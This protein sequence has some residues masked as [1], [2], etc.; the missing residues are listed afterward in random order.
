[1]ATCQSLY[2]VCNITDVCHFS[3]VKI[4]SFLSSI[5]SFDTWVMSYCRIAAHLGFGLSVLSSMGFIALCCTLIAM[6]NFELISVKSVDLCLGLYV[7]TCGCL[8]GKTIFSHSIFVK[9]QLSIFWASSSVLLT[10]FLSSFPN[11][12]VL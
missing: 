7:F 5:M 1:M 11:N 4:K 2:S 9:D 3:E 8:F 6:I 12:I 10:Q